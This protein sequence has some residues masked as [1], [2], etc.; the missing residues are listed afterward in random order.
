MPY[1]VYFTKPLA[2][3]DRSQYI[4][5]CC[6]GGDVILD[7][8]ELAIRSRYQDVQANQEDWGWFIW[9][10]KD[11]VGLA[12]DIHCEDPEAGAYRLHLT[13]RAKRFLLPDRVIDLPELDE[14]KE[15][16]VTR[17]ENEL[18]VACRVERL[19]EHYDP[20]GT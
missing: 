13:S 18:G 6:V 1:G 9:F 5:E 17:I 10:A 8:L 11:K 2:I 4:N 20:A 14:M 15:L 16:V 3:T 19:D 12:V 7:A